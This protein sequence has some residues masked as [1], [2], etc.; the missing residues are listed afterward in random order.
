[1]TELKVNWFGQTGSGRVP[2]TIECLVMTYPLT[3]QLG[4]HDKKGEQMLGF[5]FSMLGAKVA[6]LAHIEILS[7]HLRVSN[8]SD[9]IS[10]FVLFFVS[11]ASVDVYKKQIPGYNVL[12]Y[13]SAIPLESYRTGKSKKRSLISV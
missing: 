5:T 7:R 8:Q 1:M 3:C 4:E 10:C 13:C 11:V 6:A 9:A 2:T 12:L